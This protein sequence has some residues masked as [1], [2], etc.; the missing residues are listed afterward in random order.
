MASDADPKV[1]SLAL[2]MLAY[3]A[4]NTGFDTKTA[5]AR[6][7][8]ALALDPEYGEAHYALAFTLAISDRS[9]GKDHF[10]KAMKLGVP[11]TRNLRG[12]FYGAGAP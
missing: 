6:Y 10:E 11:D 4:I 7:E 1:A 5:T 9:A 8:K 12:Q 2:R 3:L